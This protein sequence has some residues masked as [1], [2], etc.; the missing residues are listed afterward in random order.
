LFYYLEAF[1]PNVA[2]SC[3]DQ[4]KQKLFR[5]RHAGAKGGGGIAPAHS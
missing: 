4:K 1:D 3:P 5:Y 2:I